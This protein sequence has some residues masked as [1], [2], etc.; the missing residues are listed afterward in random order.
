MESRRDVVS[1]ELNGLRVTTRAE[2]AALAK[3]SRSS[4]GGQKAKAPKVESL[5]YEEAIEELES[6][7]EKIESGEIGLEESIEAYERGLELRKHC[8]G[9]L[10]KAE[11]RFIDLTKQ[12]ESDSGEGDE[13]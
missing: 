1:V 13:G 4:R 10:K 5:Q 6:L 12:V 2:H 7:I 11:Q 8:D 3:A 9:I